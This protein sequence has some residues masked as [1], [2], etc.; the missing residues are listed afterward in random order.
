MHKGIKLHEAEED[1]SPTGATTVSHLTP[2][3]PPPWDTLRKNQQKC[4]EIA[5]EPLEENEENC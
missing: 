3:C 1:V 5:N 4:R 2:E